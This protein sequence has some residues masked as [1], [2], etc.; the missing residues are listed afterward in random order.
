MATTRA[1]HPR[2]PQ[3]PAIKPSPNSHLTEEGALLLRKAVQTIMK[4]P[5]TFDMGI[6]IEHQHKRG[7]SRRVGPRLPTPYCGT[8]ACLAGHVV[9]L[10]GVNP[11]KIDRDDGAVLRHHLPRTIAPVITTVLNRDYEAIGLSM[12]SDAQIFS[13]SDVA[14]V[15]LFGKSGVNDSTVRGAAERLYFVTS[16]PRKFSRPYNEAMK[17]LCDCGECTPVTD[18]KKVRRL[19]TQAARA[20]K[21]RVEHFIK[22]G[23]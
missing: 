21:A 8:T 19:R 9:I 7:R 1:K 16:W 3:R 5:T 10:A 4:Y 20:L 12:H 6:W 13:V 18:P 14:T 11:R 15:L 2:T 17:P 22:T 23:E